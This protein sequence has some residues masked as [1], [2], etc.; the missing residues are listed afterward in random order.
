[1]DPILL[2]VVLAIVVLAL[3]AMAVAA[4]RRRDAA[5]E[6]TRLGPSWAPTFGEDEEDV[7]IDLEARERQVADL[8]ERTGV[9]AR[10]VRVVVEVWHEYLTVLGLERLP[11]GHRYRI[12]DPYNPPVAKRDADGRP[13]PDRQRVARDLGTRTEVAERDAETVLAALDRQGAEPGRA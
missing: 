3:A 4:R 2:V 5:L 12:Y 8:A 10:H 6:P 13:A 7:T 1:L 11:A 9:D